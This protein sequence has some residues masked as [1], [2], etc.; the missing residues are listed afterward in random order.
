MSFGSFRAGGIVIGAWGAPALRGLMFAL[1]AALLLA[2]GAPARADI[3]LSGVAFS[4]TNS[5]GT[6]PI[7]YG[8][9]TAP[10]GYTLFMSSGGFSS[11]PTYINTA[12]VTPDLDYALTTGTDVI[13]GYM[14]YGGLTYGA[15]SLFFGGSTTAGISVYASQTSSLTSIPTFAAD[16][17]PI[18]TVTLAVV[19]GAGSLSYDNGT[20][21][22]TLT[23]YILASTSLISSLS[24]PQVGPHAV[25]GG[26]P[27]IGFEMT[28]TV[29]NDNTAMPEPMSLALIVPAIGGLLAVRRGRRDGKTRG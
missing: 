5:T 9:T 12:Q 16:G 7:G 10:A 27:T 29:T 20:Q 15:T 24:V 28:L 26:G 19:D 3:I 13:S 4:G 18:A 1:L 14:S 23:N 2:S 8:T 6:G 11:T 22:V 17:N 25:T 21:T